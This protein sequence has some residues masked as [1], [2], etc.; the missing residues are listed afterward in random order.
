MDAHLCSHKNYTNSN[1]TIIAKNQK[2]SKGNSTSE[3]VNKLGYIHN[4]KYS[5]VKKNELLTHAATSMNLKG[6]IISESRKS[7]KESYSVI[8]FYDIP[9]ITKLQ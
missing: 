4:W 8:P 6:I 5:A 9:E 3:W 2:Q 7:Q 1:S